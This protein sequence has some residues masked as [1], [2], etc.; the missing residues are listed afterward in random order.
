VELLLERGVLIYPG[1]FF[2]PSGEG[3]VRFA[4]VPTLEECER[5]AA[6]LEEL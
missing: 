1:S 5:A 6:I 2:G 3:Y 4:L